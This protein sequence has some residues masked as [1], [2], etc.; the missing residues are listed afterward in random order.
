M[1]LLGRHRPTENIFELLV[2]I[3]GSALRKIAA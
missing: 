3:H 2:A 1:E